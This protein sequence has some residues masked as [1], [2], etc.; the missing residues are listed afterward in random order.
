MSGTQSGGN[1]REAPWPKGK[2]YRVVAVIVGAGILLASIAIA[3]NLVDEG[4]RNLRL[5]E[6][7]G[8][9]TY[10]VD[11]L[12]GG[13]YGRW[14]Y[15]I[16]S[17]YSGNPTLEGNVVTYP[18]GGAWYLNASMLTGTAPVVGDF[19][20]EEIGESWFVLTVTDIK[21]DGDVDD[22]DNL[23]ISSQNGTFADD[24]AYYFRFTLSYFGGIAPYYL[25]LGFQFTGSGFDSWV[26]DEPNEGAL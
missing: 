19:G 1:G 12:P 17:I 4:P 5:D 25:V 16:V 20:S 11:D 9:I 23:E 10:T 15:A 26:E 7:D 22:G 8:A 13:F 2:D 24:T 3:V 21:G 6:S 14:D 18:I